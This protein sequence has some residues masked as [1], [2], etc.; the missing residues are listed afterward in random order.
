MGALFFCLSC[1]LSYP[2]TFC[3]GYLFFFIFIVFIWNLRVFNIL[4]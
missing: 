1:G 4:I 3:F 2:F